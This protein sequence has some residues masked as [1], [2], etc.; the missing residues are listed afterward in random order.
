M[1]KKIAQ[2]ILGLFKRLPL[3]LICLSL[4]IFI[5][6]IGTID[7]KYIGLYKSQQKYF[8]SFFF[9]LFDVI[10]F[11]GA[12]L[13]L[14]VIFI[15]LC[16]NFISNF[17]KYK[18]KLGVIVVHVSVGLLLLGGFVTA[19]FSVEGSMVIEEGEVVDFY[20]DYHKMEFNIVETI[21]NIDDNNF[22]KVI[23]FRQGYLKKNEVLTHSQFSGKI[24]VLKFYENCRIVNRF[25]S[26]DP[27]LKG[28]AKRFDIRKRPYDKEEDK[29]I[30]AMVVEL[31]G[32]GEQQNGIYLVIERM[33]KRDFI[34]INDKKYF[35]QLKNLHYP[36]PFS[37]ECVD[38]KKESYFGTDKAKEYSSKVKVKDKEVTTSRLIRMNHPLRLYNY[39]F[40]QASF[41]DGTQLGG[42]DTT[43]LAVV[44]NYGRLFPYISSIIIC[45]GLLL[46]IFIR[47]PQLIKKKD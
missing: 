23:S 46:Q 47:V 38:F 12:R 40:Y 44:K 9:L 1:I 36:L 24:K 11:P 39:T 26:G 14:I 28:V 3:F 20:Q 42:K 29:N 6:V 4:L 25:N 15:N 19:Y 5:L 37:I 34:N 18:K 35:F 10:P 17:S 33:I 27:K 31:S 32:V 7:Q 2:K 8:S 30:A 22:N 43:V 13:L 41:I 21:S 45:V 16:T